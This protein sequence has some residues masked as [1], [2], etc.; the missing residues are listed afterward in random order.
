MSDKEFKRIKNACVTRTDQADER[1]CSSLRRASNSEHLFEALAPYCN[2]MCIEYLETIAYAYKNDSLLNLIKNYSQVIFSKPLREVWNYVPFY[3]VKD[4]YY[5]E[6][7]AIFE[8]KDP[9][10]LTVEEL[11]RRKPQLAKEIAMLITVVRIQSLLISWLIPTSKVYQTYLS[12]LTVPQ[13]LRN[14][15][16]VK[17]GNWM[18]YLPQFILQEQQKKFG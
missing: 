9:D 15:S 10:N 17:F 18:A 13:Q 7:T 6:L 8:D 16:L 14:D 1:L 12:F 11:N 4:K 3:S 2:W 5:T